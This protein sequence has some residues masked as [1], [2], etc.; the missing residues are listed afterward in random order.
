MDAWVGARTGSDGGYLFS[1]SNLWT[2]T[3]YRVVTRTQVVVASRLVTA[4]SAVRPGLRVR[5]VSR[6][7]ATVLG[8]VVPAVPGTAALQRY[9]RGAGWRQAQL[10]P[11]APA[12]AT[13]SRYAFSVRRPRHGRPARRFRVLVTPE[14]GAYVA[15]KSRSVQVRPRPR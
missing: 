15:R 13:R 4:Y 10:A 9:V 7:R 11:I 3:R 14:R 2:T 8:S 1:I 12:D 5:H 6:R